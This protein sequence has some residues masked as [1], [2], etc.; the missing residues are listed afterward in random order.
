MELFKWTFGN[1]LC[2]MCVHACARVLL[3]STIQC[4][5]ASSKTPQSALMLLNKPYFATGKCLICAPTQHQ[6]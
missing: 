6:L 3:A 5:M 1:Q 2:S 4:C